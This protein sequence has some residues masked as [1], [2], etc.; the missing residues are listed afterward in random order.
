MKLYE[1][2]LWK[3]HYSH[4]RVL[5]LAPDVKTARKRARAEVSGTASG[6]V[7][8]EDKKAIQGKPD[9]YRAP[10]AICVIEGE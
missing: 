4:S 7:S 8:S 3:S 1:W 9:V 5:V 6:C 2:T 10:V